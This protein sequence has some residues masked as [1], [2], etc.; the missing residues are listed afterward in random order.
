MRITDKQKRFCE[1]YLIDLNGTQAAI[2]AGYS[3]N[4]AKEQAY[5][6]LTKPH[7][8][9]FICKLQ[10]EIR[11][12]NQIT[13]DT[14]IQKLNEWIE[15]DITETINLNFSELKGLPSA[16]RNAIAS[17]KLNRTSTSDGKII[18]ETVE[19]KLVSKERAIEMLAKHL[20][21]YEKHNTQKK[22]T[23]DLNLLDTE[24]LLKLKN[25]SVIA[26]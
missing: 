16:L 11:E 26:N 7:I 13:V 9:E 24:T 17:L 5:E 18:N 2:R 20:G 22:T 14:L 6:N 15:A 10:R 3:S 8:Q 4:T 19:V 25:A 1:E 21:F 12:R 23:I